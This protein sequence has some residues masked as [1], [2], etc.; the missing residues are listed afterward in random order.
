MKQ[1]KE[2]C[3]EKEITY[4][5]D[6]AAMSLLG[7]I[8]VKKEMVKLAHKYRVRLETE[9]SKWFDMERRPLGGGK[10]LELMVGNKRELY[11]GPAIS[12]RVSDSG[13]DPYY[14]K[15]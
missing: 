14:M 9:T 13:T 5:A 2:T 6:K 8:G 4:V 15:I 1:K 3:K 7:E 10:Y 12:V 11:G